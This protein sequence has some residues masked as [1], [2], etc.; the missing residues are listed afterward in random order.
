MP[1]IS[2]QLQEQVV[3]WHHEQNMGA[4]KIA[5][6]AGCSEWT[7]YNLLHLHCEFGQVTN[8]YACLPGHPCTLDMHAM[9]YIS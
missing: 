3:V 9:N 5:E 6:L 1:Q 7:V 2:D 4:L 8:P